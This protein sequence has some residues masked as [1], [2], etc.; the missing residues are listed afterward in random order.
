[1]ETE[2]SK[3]AGMPR[4]QCHK[5][6][7]ALKIKEVISQPD[8]GAGVNRYYIVPTDDA[9]TRVEVSAEWLDKHKPMAGGYY[10]VY[11]DGYAS[12]SPAKAFEEG[13]TLVE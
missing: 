10:V 3:P 7:S 6:V 9:Q 11:E 2:Q 8:V 4:Y 12:Y 13:Y 1:M 5:E